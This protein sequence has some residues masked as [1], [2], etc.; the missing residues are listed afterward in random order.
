MTGINY[1]ILSNAKPL[2]VKQIEELEN[3]VVENAQAFVYL[4]TDGKLCF[5]VP[6]GIDGINGIKDLAWNV[7]HELSKE[8]DTIIRKSYVKLQQFKFLPDTI[9]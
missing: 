8:N 4:D 3:Q 9:E 6:H 5:S 7:A 2:S 1:G